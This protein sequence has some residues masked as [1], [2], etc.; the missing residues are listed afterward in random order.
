[1]GTLK[2]ASTLTRLCVRGSN[3]LRNSQAVTGAS[4]TISVGAMKSK[5]YTFNDPIEH[6]TGPDKYEL[7]QAQAGN[8]NPFDTYV[9]KPDAAT[10]L[11][12]TLPILIPSLNESRMVGCCCENDYSEI[13]WFNLEAK[14][15]VQRCDCGYHF[16]LFKHD[17]LDSRIQPKFGKGF[18]SGMSPYY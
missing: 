3:L 17:P 18:G 16:K 10:G 1:M 2:M 15:G 4:R 9:I 11:K 8:D 12:A 7:M 13:V 5:D 6:A 14:S